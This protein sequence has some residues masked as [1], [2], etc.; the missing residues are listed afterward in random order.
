MTNTTPTPGAT[1]RRNA[2]R[3]AMRSR[4]AFTLAEVAT[5]MAISGVVVA[6]LGS[7]LMLSTRALP[8][9]ETLTGEDRRLARALDLI[10]EDLAAGALFSRLPELRRVTAGI[11]QAVAKEA[12][13]A[14]VAEPM[15]DE[16]L[17]EKVAAAMWEP[18]YPVL[19][20]V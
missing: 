14:G 18:E 6:G 1:T 9:A 16:V 17:A 10:A 12:A 11:A 13:S 8:A 3:R 2:A 7:A 4:P 20:A 5:A 15:D 19:E